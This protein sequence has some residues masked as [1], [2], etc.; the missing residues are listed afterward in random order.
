[1]VTAKFPTA[2]RLA[3]ARSIYAYVATRIGYL[4]ET[5]F[6]IGCLAVGAF[7]VGLYSRYDHPIW[8][9]EFLHFAFGAMT[10]TAEAWRWISETILTLNFNQTGIYMIIDYWLLHIFGASAIALRLP[11]LLST[12]WLMICTMTFFRS[13]GYSNIWS[14]TALLA[15]V[16]TSSLMDYAGEARPYMPLAAAAVGTFAFY[17]APITQR[18]W[19]ITIVGFASVVLGALM[20]PYFATYWIAIVCLGALLQLVD[21]Q[22]KLNTTAILSFVNPSLI[23]VG[24]TIYTA[25]GLS[26]WMR[27]AMTLNFDPFQ[28]VHADRLVV[29]MIDFSHLNFFYNHGPTFQTEPTPQRSFLIFIVALS[30][31]TFIMPRRLQV[32]L[33]TLTPPVALAVGALAISGIL[34]WISYRHHYWIL[35]RQWIA[36]I[37]LMPIAIVWWFAEAGRQLDRI[38]KGLSIILAATLIYIAGGSVANITPQRLATLKSDIAARSQPN[39]PIPEPTEAPAEMDND[40]WVALANKNIE[41]GGPVWVI[42]SRFY[43]H[44]H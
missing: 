3:A 24:A 28:W 7:G 2:E 41:Q 14:F 8:I 42:F 9:D 10:T 32:Y 25:V 22:L 29:T 39:T 40:K 21:G 11:S 43:I 23:L 1:M 4:T 31:V 44:S 37:A 19:W 15:L 26:S 6:F 36:S 16:A 20:H 12:V 5:I 17:A 27:G 33:L 30:V 13:R 18:R 35:D 34:S 38:V